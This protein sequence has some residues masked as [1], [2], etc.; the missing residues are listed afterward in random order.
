M[1]MRVPFGDWSCDGH[2]QKGD[3]WVSVPTW[4]SIPKAQSRVRAQYG[5]DFF[6][7]MSHEYDEYTLG[8]LHWEA[9]YEA[10]YDTWDL[11]QDTHRGDVEYCGDKELDT[12][13]FDFT[14]EVIKHPE[15]WYVYP[16]ALIRM[17]FMLMNQHGANA[18]ILNYNPFPYNYDI[19]TVGY[20]AFS[21]YEC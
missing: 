10:G 4:D 16:E 2:K 8:E 17:F 5:D 19:E 20:G 7:T 15:N 1:I 21:A 9:L 18:T 13:D 12:N 6:R 3:I 14:E 11:V